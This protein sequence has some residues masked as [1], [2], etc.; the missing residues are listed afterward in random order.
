MNPRIPYYCPEVQ[1]R[2]D[3]LNERINRGCTDAYIE[4][5]Q[6]AVINSS[7][8]LVDFDKVIDAKIA[9]AR[10]AEEHDT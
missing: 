8:K 6:F 7:V 10:K 4:L 9:S 2:V 5:V 1:A 3:E